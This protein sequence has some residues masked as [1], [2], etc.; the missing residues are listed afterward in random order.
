N[1]EPV[2]ISKTGPEDILMLDISIMDPE[3]GVLL[4]ID[5]VVSENPTLGSSK[6][7]GEVGLGFIVDHLGMFA[8]DA[9]YPTKFSQFSLFTAAF[10]RS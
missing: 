6:T 9:L 2:C 8:K 5:T 1:A 4:E 3:S 10:K 7:S